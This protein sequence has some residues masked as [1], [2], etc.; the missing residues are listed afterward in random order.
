MQRFFLGNILET[1][2]FVE[3]ATANDT[4]FPVYV[5]EGVAVQIRCVR[6]L[7]NMHDAA[8][9]A[10]NQGASMHKQLASVTL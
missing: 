9:H 10:Y 3:Q 1:L 8:H 2:T 5:I 4:L 7:P 6:L